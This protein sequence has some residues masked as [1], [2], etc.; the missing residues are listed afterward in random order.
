MHSCRGRGFVVVMHALMPGWL[1]IARRPIQAPNLETQ[2]LDARDTWRF[3]SSFIF[4]LC[5]CDLYNSCARFDQN[6][7][8]ACDEARPK[9]MTMALTRIRKLHTTMATPG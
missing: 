2:C 1:R 8:Y 9:R 5:R 4:N 3:V 7:L 6:V